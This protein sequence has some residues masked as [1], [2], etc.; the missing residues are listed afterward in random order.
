MNHLVEILTLKLICLNMQQKIDIKNVSQIDTS[1][2]AL[3]LTSLKTENDKLDV[4]KLKSLPNNLCNLKSKVDKLDTD[5][6]APVP[7]NL[8]KLSNA[9]KNEVV[10]KLNIMLR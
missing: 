8:S 7:A 2:F 9:V 1:S 3:N 6:L 5:Q 4:D 10:K